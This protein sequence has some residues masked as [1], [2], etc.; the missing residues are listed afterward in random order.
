L[1]SKLEGIIEHLVAEWITHKLYE[2]FEDSKLSEFA[3]RTIHLEQ[4]YQELS[5]L[6]NNL[7]YQYLKEK[8]SFIDRGMRGAFASQLLRK[9]NKGGV[10]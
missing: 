5:R 6:K 1:E 8:H 7:Q 9:R 4:S 10:C 3:A 2:I